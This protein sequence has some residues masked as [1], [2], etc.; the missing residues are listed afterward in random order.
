[1]VGTFEA[2]NLKFETERLLRRSISV[3]RATAY[4]PSLNQFSS[5]DFSS[6][7]RHV[8][9]GVSRDRGDE[10]SSPVPRM[11]SNVTTE[12]SSSTC[13]IK[14]PKSLQIESSPDTLA[15]KTSSF[16]EGSRLKSVVF[17][18]EA[19]DSEIYSGSSYKKAVE[20]A[21][22]CSKRLSDGMAKVTCP[23]GW[24][25]ENGI[26][27]YKTGRGPN[28]SHGAEHGEMLIASPIKQCI[29]GIGGVYDF[30]MLELSPMTVAQ[31]RD[32]ADNYRKVQ[33]GSVYDEDTSDAFIDNLA[34]KFWRRLG[35]T[36]ESAR[37]GADIG[38]SLF[39]GADACG[40][41]I[42]KLDSC[43]QLLRIDQAD[44]DLD[45]TVCLPGVMSAYLY[46]GMW[47]SV[48]AA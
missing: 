23:E 25:D 35:P 26:A 27:N 12:D 9:L 39:K 2:A 30:T 40:W 47:A 44:G 4:T 29:S 32:D 22:L 48:F 20:P 8:V 15:A 42:D 43:L 19:A 24:W 28:W 16:V 45:D 38:G 6:F 36:M 7:I 3:Q 34:L 41:N 37:Y 46:V 31:F 11:A 17:D 10:F 13:Q 1:M 14:T 5:L 21:K 18:V 33:L